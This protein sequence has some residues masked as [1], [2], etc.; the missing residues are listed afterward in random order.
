MS[1]VKILIQEF[2]N[3]S[4]ASQGLS[5]LQVGAYQFFSHVWLSS[6]SSPHS[7]LS[8]LFPLQSSLRCCG[9]ESYSDWEDSP[10]VLAQEKA[11]VGISID[12]KRKCPCLVLRCRLPVANLPHTNVGWAT[13]VLKNMFSFKRSDFMKNK[14][15]ICETVLTRCD[16]TRATSTTLAV[17]TPW[18][19][20]FQAISNWSVDG[21]QILQFSHQFNLST[22][23]IQIKTFYFADLRC[24]WAF[25]GHTSFWIISLNQ[26][27]TNSSDAVKSQ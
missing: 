14:K 15:S 11:K 1:G 9:A 7:H 22:T 21:W 5:H 26:T 19:K 4:V 12:W 24:S 20:H 3:D 17:P 10:W 23:H 16:S 13:V 25:G 18:R 27:Q 2:R 8:T 6:P